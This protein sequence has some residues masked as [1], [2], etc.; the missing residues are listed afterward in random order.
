MHDP[1]IQ[2]FTGEEFFQH[3]LLH[4]R[5]GKSHWRKR[6]GDHLD[7][8]FPHGRLGDRINAVMSAVGYNPRL[9]LE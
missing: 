3:A 2:Y 8:N 7:R 6:I 5:S 4:E 9:I 1:C